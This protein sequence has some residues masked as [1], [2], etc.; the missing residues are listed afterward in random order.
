MIDKPQQNNY[1]FSVDL[2]DIRLRLHA[3]EKYKERVPQNTQLYLDWL[4]KYNANCTFFVTGD[5]ATIYP[6]LIKKIVDAGH[7]IGCHTYDHKP[8]DKQTPKEFKT[9]LEKNILALQKAGAK[10]IQ[11]FRAPIFSLTKKTAWAYNV[12]AELGFQYSSSVLPAKNPLYGWD[13][14]G[15][16]LKQINEKIVEIPLTV[17]KFGF[18]VI[19]PIG[20]VYFRVLPKLF[21]Q[22]IAKQNLKKNLPLVGYLHPYDIDTKQERYMNPGIDNSKFYNFLLYFNRKNVFHRLDSIMKLGF[23]ICTYKEYLFNNFKK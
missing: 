4:K 20:G 17:G 2:E 5:V 18:L 19:P 8:I 15:F 10:D 1:L 12:L 21:V 9:D 16:K 23:Q 11:G 13:S 6:D 3:P 14:F 22:Y 7:E